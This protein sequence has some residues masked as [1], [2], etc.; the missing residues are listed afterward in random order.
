MSIA[1][2]RYVDITSGVG[3]GSDVSTRSLIGRYFTDNPLVPTGTFLEFTSADDVGTYFGTTSQEYLR[4]VFYFGWISKKITRPKKISFARWSD[5]ATAPQI[6]GAPGAQSITTWNAITTGGFTLNM[7]GITHQISGLN[8]SSDANLAAVASRIQSAVNAESFPVQFTGSIAISHPAS[9]TGVITTSTGIDT[10]TV[11][12]ITGTIAI[13]QVLNGAGVS[14]GT[15]ITSFG[16]GTGGNGTYI[17]SSSGQTVSSEAM[18][19]GAAFNTLTAT[20]TNGI[21]AIGQLITGTGVTG[22][23]TITAFGTG[24]G[25]NGTYILSS[26]SLTVSSE[27]MTAGVAS[28]L[29][30]AATVTF[31]AIRSAFNLNGGATGVANISVVAGTG[32]TDI[33]NQL[34]WLSTSTVLSAGSIQQSVT[35]VLIQSSGASNNFGSFAFMPALTNT[36]IVQ[37]A[38]WNNDQNIVFMYSVPTAAS[39]A[40]ALSGLLGDIGGVTIT[41]SPLAA[42][43]PEMAPMMILAATDY[44]TIDAVENYEFQIFNLTPSVLTDADANLYDGLSINY[45]GQTQT[46]GQLL[47]FYQ[48]GVMQGLPVDPLDQNVY[49][50]EIWLKDAAGAA[51]MTLLLALAQVPANNK[52]RSQILAVLQ[53]VIDQAL[54]NGTI[55]VGKTLST[56]QQLFITEQTGDPKAWYQVQNTG[57]WVDVVIVPFEDHGTTKYKAV[58]TLIYSKDDIIRLIEGSDVLI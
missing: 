2:S 42:E 12:G 15:T 6:F 52:G 1:L 55:S 58:Y 54:R 57:Y 3:A 17:L 10:L 14:G 29:W 35:D 51:L 26:N 25:G 45:Y 46:A 38:E 7:G 27:S 37:A 49:A 4:A 20:N 9:F 13:G 8:F 44:T 32:G 56:I 41:L 53:S 24:T 48:Q 19:S 39:N 33:A 22:S 31:D 16:T 5:T 34:G 30:S 18:T 50:N 28:T 47:Q 21:F 36:Q 23:P 43:Y 11:S 40:S